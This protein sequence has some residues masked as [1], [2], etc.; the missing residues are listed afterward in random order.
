MK[1]PSEK[2]S[3]S[4]S[5]I[6][7]GRP[8]ANP[9]GNRSW[10]T[11][12][13]QVKSEFISTD[14]LDHASESQSDVLRISED[15]FR[16]LF[17]YLSD[18]AICTDTH[19]LITMINPAFSTIFGYA[20]NE[21]IGKK[22]DM[23]YADP[24]DSQKFSRKYFH[25]GPESETGAFE[26]RYRRK[27]GS[28]FWAESTSTQIRDAAGNVIGFASFHRDID[29][30]KQVEQTLQKSHEALEEDVRKRTAEL[31]ST[32]SALENEMQERKKAEEQLRQFARVF[33]D[34]TDPILIEDLSGTIIALN[35]E[36]EKAYGW[37]REEL[38]GRSIKTIIPPDDYWRADQLRQRCRKDGEVRNWEDTRQDQYGRIYSVLITAFQLTDE[39]G[40]PTALAT[41]AK[42]ITI[43]KYMEKQLMESRQR[44]RE[45]SRKSIEALEND[46][47][48]VSKELHDSI[49][50]SLSA[51]KFGLETILDDPAPENIAIGLKKMV[52]HLADTIKETKRISASLRPLTLD[53]LGLL[54]TLSW[55]TRRFSDSYKHINLVQ[56]VGIKEHEV[57]EDLKIVIYRV[58]Q[59]ALNNIAKHSKA[60]TVHILLNKQGPYL[61]LEIRDNGCG[62][63]PDELFSRQ[64]PLIG[65]GLKG[66][67][68]RAEICGGSFTLHAEPDEG[69]Q[70]KITLPLRP[71]I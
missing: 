60:D 37:R 26:V 31:Q 55:Y 17:D 30:R 3:I 66:M 45:L 15:Q 48:T 62:F 52:T 21:V 44:L 58:L 61:V 10:G 42:D 33:M 40:R 54:A 32:V 68:E 20:T 35:R 4:E 8:H 59:E 6:E 14:R 67:Q 65:Y 18:A 27:D 63:D 34:S 29:Q 43:R 38:I 7:K 57:P 11:R 39:A 9:S 69:T 2:T 64:D 50:A 47:R 49:G 25:T 46:R 12:S 19:D 41:I 70:L 23:L 5:A 53:D 36:A 16:S 22:A 28:V 71:L 51:I 56:Q 24:K 1:K 13:P